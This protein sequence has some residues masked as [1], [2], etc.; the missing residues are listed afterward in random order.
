MNINIDIGLILTV[1]FGVISL[2]GFCIAWKTWN[3]PKISLVSES[4]TILANLTH[5]SFEISVAYKDEVISNNLIF[6]S[7]HLINNGNVDIDVRDVE[8]PITVKLPESA[9]WM[10][11]EIKNNKH[12]MKI[13]ES[14]NKN[15]LRL[16]TGLWKKGEGFKFNALI[17]FDND[18]VLLGRKKIFDELVVSS[19]IK[20]LGS[21]KILTLGEEKTYK[22]KFAKILRLFV[23]PSL[24][25]GIYICLG[26]IILSGVL[27]KDKYIL[28]AY[29]DS[30][31]INLKINDSKPSIYQGDLA[32]G[33]DVIEKV[34]SIKLMAEKVNEKEEHR[35]MGGVTILMGVLLFILLTHK[36]F[37][38]Y[39]LRRKIDKN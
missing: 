27:N 7:A 32:L 24:A 39:L 30:E 1:I 18:D 20:G 17:A 26:L 29:K 11:F 34:D 22:S 23:Y 9:K 28:N 2:F 16:K 36:D 3:R 10:T 14:L 5:T 38:S 15:N 31:V 25:S 8:E 33:G 13:E 6:I 35:F 21:V 19:R 4:S 12:G 37:K